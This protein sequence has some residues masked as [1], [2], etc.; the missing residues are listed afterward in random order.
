LLRLDGSDPSTSHVFEGA[1][2]VVGL[3]PGMVDIFLLVSN[4]IYLVKP[5]ENSLGSLSYPCFYCLVSV[6][7]PA[8]RCRYERTMSAVLRMI[9]VDTRAV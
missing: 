8:Q 9:D 3:D 4:R 2:A 1:A 5:Y 6:Y 7:P